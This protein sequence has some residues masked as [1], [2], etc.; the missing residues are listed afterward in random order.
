MKKFFLVLTALFSANLYAQNCEQIDIRLAD[1]YGNMKKYGSY[2]KYEERDY[3]KLEIA[4]KQFTDTLS[5][6]LK[7]PESMQCEFI[8]TGEAGVYILRSDDNKLRTFSWD[9]QSGGSMHDASAIYQYIDNQNNVVITTEHANGFEIGPL[10][11]QLS[12]I[13][14]LDKI[15]YLAVDLSIGDGRNHMISAIFYQITNNG[16]E[17]ANIIQ[18]SKLTNEINVAFDPTLINNDVSYPD[19]TYDEQTQTLS[20]PVIMPSED[21]YGSGKPTNEKIQYKF[22]GQ[23]FVRIKN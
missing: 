12:T 19:F 14:L 18:T 7:T 22:N 23:H 16:L 13:K 21:G 2:G 15:Y 20:F 11:Y 8:K 6:Y 17:Y 10:T 3:D 1:S 5:A 4:I 9:E